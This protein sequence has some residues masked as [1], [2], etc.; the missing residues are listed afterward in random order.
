MKREN[1]RQRRG[2]E[3]NEAKERREGM[4]HRG[5]GDGGRENIFLVLK[6]CEW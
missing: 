3:R 6:N 5:R 2:G 4:K 1:R